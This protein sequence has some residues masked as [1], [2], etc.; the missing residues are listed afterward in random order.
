MFCH[1]AGAGLG[2]GAA[3]GSW[4]FPPFRI[5]PDGTAF[6]TAFLEVNPFSGKDEPS[7]PPSGHLIRDSLSKGLDKGR[8]WC[9]R[10]VDVMS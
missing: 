5:E 7:R 9:I 8:G 10:E 4:P 2:K 3:F 1:D 6:A